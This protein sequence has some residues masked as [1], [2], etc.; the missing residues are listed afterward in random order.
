MERQV[1][2]LLSKGLIRP[3]SSPYGSPVLF[4]EK[5]GKSLR[6]CVDY[7]AVNKLTAKDKHPLPRIDDLLDLWSRSKLL[8]RPEALPTA[9]CC[10][11]RPSC[12]TAT[13]QNRTYQTAGAKLAKHRRKSGIPTASK[14]N[15][16]IRT[17]HTSEAFRPLTTASSPSKPNGSTRQTGHMWVRQGC[18]FIRFEVRTREAPRMTAWLVS[19]QRR[20]RL[21]GRVGRPDPTL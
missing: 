9:L 15:Q 1:K 14:V 16:C 13:A 3:S 4:V 2:D 10:Y 5:K 20:A 6:M 12:S 21:S 19:R 11:V 7:R 8:P 18:I 17:T